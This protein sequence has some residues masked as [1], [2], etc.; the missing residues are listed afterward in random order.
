MKDNDAKE[1]VTRSRTILTSIA[2]IGGTETERRRRYRDKGTSA[3]AQI[4]HRTTKTFTT[5]Y[6]T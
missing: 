1:K 5:V 4:T 6:N 3:H 2:Q